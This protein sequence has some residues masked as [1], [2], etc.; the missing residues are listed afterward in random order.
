MRLNHVLAEGPS[1]PAPRGR[2]RGAARE[3]PGL[4]SRNHRLVRGTPLCGV[5]VMGRAGLLQE[6][7]PGGL[8]KSGDQG[9]LLRKL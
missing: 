8:T 1:G 7:Q 2:A 6:H 3:S 5:T 4:A 9:G